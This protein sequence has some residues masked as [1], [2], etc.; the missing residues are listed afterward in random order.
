VEIEVDNNGLPYPLDPYIGVVI[1]NL[2]YLS[3]EDEEGVLLVQLKNSVHEEMK[4][5]DRPLFIPIARLQR[6]IPLTQRA[7][8]ILRDRLE[9]MGLHLE[10]AIL[11]NIFRNAI[12]RRAYR[13]AFRGGDA[14]VDILFQNARTSTDQALREAVKEVI[15]ARAVADTGY[16]S[17][18][19]TW[20]FDAFEF[21]RHDAYPKGIGGRAYVNDAMKVLEKCSKRRGLDSN[22][23][24]PLK[25][26]GPQVREKYPDGTLLDIFSF[27]VFKNAAKA[28]M[29][30]FE[31][32]LE[33]D[34]STLVLF[35]QW[36]RSFHKHHETIQLEVIARELP[37]YIRVIGIEPTIKAIWLLGCFVQYDHIA[38]YVYASSFEEYDWYKGPDFEIKA[39]DLSSLPAPSCHDQDNRNEV[40]DISNKST[41]ESINVSQQSTRETSHDNDNEGSSSEEVKEKAVPES[42]ELP[43]ED[44][45]DHGNTSQDKSQDEASS[46][47]K[48]PTAKKKVAKKKVAKKAAKKAS[49][50]QES[51]SNDTDIS[52]D[53]DSSA[54]TT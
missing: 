25:K 24:E 43:F 38:P 52:D 47:Q 3:L 37:D 54:S 34:F 14:L 17:G 2:P 39:I 19:N 8:R 26:A 45:E 7:Y 31:N 32:S 15:I 13:R 46:T 35:L 33:I 21:T 9:P 1:E 5:S 12:Q 49:A 27:D 48:K 18:T 16:E 23:L 42:P 30:C 11:E 29:A 36:K 28:S 51:K 41:P 50:K 22:L 40:Q 4:G 20:L 10:Q 44:N 6:V 53:N